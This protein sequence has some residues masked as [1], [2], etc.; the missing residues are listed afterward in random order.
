MIIIFICLLMHI[1][2][3]SKLLVTEAIDR[4]L[5]ISLVFFLGFWY[6]LPGALIEIFSYESL[7]N[8]LYFLDF[9][10]Y[11]FAYSLES[12]TVFA[13][14]I[15]VLHYAERKALKQLPMK[16]PARL[17][18]FM[19]VSFL[20]ILVAGLLIGPSFNYLESNSAELYSTNSFGAQVLSIFNGLLLAGAILLIG[21]SRHWTIP[22]LLLFCLAG[23]S[24]SL[25]VLAGARIQLMTPIIILGYKY[26]RR[27]TLNFRTV[28][29][30]MV[31]IF[32]IFYFVIPISAFIGDIRQSGEIDFSFFNSD[33]SVVDGAALA[34]M[35]F[36]KFDSFSAGVALVRTDGIASAGLKPYYGSALLF[37]PR[38]VWP[39]RP[40][41]GSVDGT[42]YG[43]P[44]RLVPAALFNTVSDSANVGVSPLHITI[45]QFGYLGILIFVFTGVLYVL[46]INRL[47]ISP[48][49]EDKIVG[50]YLLGI[51]AFAVLIPSPDVMLKQVVFALPLLFIFKLFRHIKFQ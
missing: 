20:L 18:Y 12:V 23:L 11:I 30:I 27:M 25:A 4:I 51:P 49:F 50:V 37:I 34:N 5:A 28:C 2:A 9:E 8:S 35:L 38:A 13:V 1:F 46:F 39:D 7:R 43:H 44:S 19:I 16:I 21:H 15:L 48:Y 47:L 32:F 24:S 36:V 42:I 17:E 14:I 41:A 10:D 29:I 3:C 45:W 33:S 40:V 6:I 31:G 26:L 22:A